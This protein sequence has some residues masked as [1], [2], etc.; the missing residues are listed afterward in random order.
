MTQVTVTVNGQ[1]FRVTCGEGEE[2]RIQK[3]ADYINSKIRDL[4]ASMGQ[5]GEARLLLLAALILADE[6]FDLRANGADAS[7]SAGNQADRPPPISVDALHQAS[8]KIENIVA[9]LQNA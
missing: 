2:E 9:R 5:V 7:T 1:H 6:V 3:L 4:V 8:A